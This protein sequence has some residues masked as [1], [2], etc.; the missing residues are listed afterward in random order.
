MH[1]QVDKYSWHDMGS[2]FG[3]SDV[4]AAYLYGQLE[5]REQILAKRRHVFDRYRDHLAPHADAHG[6]RLPVI[7]HDREQAYHMFYVLLPDRQ[8]RNRV[9]AGMN[10]AGIL[11]TFHY[12]PLHT[13]PGG[14]A[15]SACEVSCPVTNAVSERLLRLPFYT[16]LTDADADRVVEAFLTALADR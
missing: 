7:G 14:R 12:V 15:V 2:S 1:G 4:L 9:L 16:S 11:A 10:D 3:L 6:Y 13:S 8:T 5:Q